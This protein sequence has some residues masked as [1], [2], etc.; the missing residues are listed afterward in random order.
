MHISM[1]KH[2][3]R[4]KQAQVQQHYRSAATKA[5]FQPTE[6][7]SLQVVA[8]VTLA[9]SVPSLDVVEVLERKQVEEKVCNTTSLT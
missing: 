3:F 2:D 9:D 4:K 8:P 5:L 1:E 7:Q 6:R